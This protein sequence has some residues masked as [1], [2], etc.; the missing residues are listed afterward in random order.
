MT[1]L[2]ECYQGAIINDGDVNLCEQRL[3]NTDFMPSTFTILKLPLELFSLIASHLPLYATASTLLSLALTNS[4]IYDIVH[5]I[6]YSCLILKNEKDAISVFQKLLTNPDLGKTVRELHVRSVLSVAT[7]YGETAFDTVTGLRQV[8]KAGVLPYL[9]TLVLRLWN[10]NG[11]WDNVKGFGRLPADFWEDFHSKCPR[12]RK[13]VLS[14]IGD[15]FND[16]QSGIYDLKG[17]KV[18]P[19]YI[20]SK[21]VVRY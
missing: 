10:V 18:C 20:V 21:K 19:L 6:L 8:I 14:G 2:P 5:N 13:V 12:M 15:P 17:M 9:H 4:A 16:Y 7:I 11:D 1:N 3:P